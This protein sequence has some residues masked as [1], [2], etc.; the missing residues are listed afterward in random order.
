MMFG[1]PGKIESKAMK[2][3]AL[4]HVLSQQ[5]GRTIIDKTGLTGEYDFVFSI[6]D[7]IRVEEQGAVQESILC[8]P[9]PTQR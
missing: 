6:S 9:A 2:V 8:T 4:A 3:D 7:A 1:G 5:L